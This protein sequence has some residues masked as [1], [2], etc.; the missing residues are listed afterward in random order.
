MK[1]YAF[2]LSLIFSLMAFVPEAQALSKDKEKSTLTAEEKQRV[3]EIETRVH[4]IQAMD[5]ASMKKEERKEV[6]NELK[7]LKKEVRQ[8]G[9]GVYVSVGAIIII[10]L[11]I[12][13]L[14]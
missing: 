6:K 11:L 4:E 3:T 14:R 1:N 5:F 2:C 8:V 12:I 13:L 9:G 7:A 10:L